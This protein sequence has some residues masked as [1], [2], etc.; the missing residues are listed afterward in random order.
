M[1]TGPEATEGFDLALTELDGGFVVRSGS[2]AGADVLAAIRHR[3]AAAEQL[4]EERRALDACAAGIERR[5]DTRDLRD[6]LFDS[7]EHPR[8]DDVAERCLACA[9]VFRYYGIKLD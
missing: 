9:N 8:W 4:L 6:L 3:P 7:L 5:L 2:P 1:G